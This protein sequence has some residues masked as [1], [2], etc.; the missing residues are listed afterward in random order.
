[1]VRPVSGSLLGIATTHVRVRV[2][3]GPSS[4]LIT[5]SFDP[6][7]AREVRTFAPADIDGI[8]L[9]PNVPLQN[10]GFSQIRVEVL[11]AVGG[12]P[13]C[14]PAGASIKGTATSDT[15]KICS[16]FSDAGSP[17]E[18]VR[19]V[20]HFDVIPSDVGRCRVRAASEDGRTS[21]PLEL[22]FGS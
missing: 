1:M 5:T 20:E 22:T 12:L 9:A 18:S 6:T 17:G 10:A 21:A 8:A 11:E 19:Y 14:I 3:D 2:P 4:N 15:P 7:F 13:V 16:V